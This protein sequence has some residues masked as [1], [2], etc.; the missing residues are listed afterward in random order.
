MTQK[1]FQSGCCYQALIPV[2]T[3]MYCSAEYSRRTLCR[4]LDLSFCD[5][6]SSLVFFAANSSWLRFL[7]FSALSP[8]L[9]VCWALCTATW[10]LFQ[11]SKPEQPQGSSCLFATSALGCLMLSVLKNTGS[12]IMSIFCLV[13]DER[14]NPCYSVLAR[15]RN[16]TIWNSYF[17]NST[18]SFLPFIIFLSKW[19]SLHLA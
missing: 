8:Q 19:Y 2:L 6:L 13:L 5:S 9:R 18:L 16:S 14:I 12:C 17:Y 10:K 7:R 11:G 4:Y 15:S 3:C 1:V